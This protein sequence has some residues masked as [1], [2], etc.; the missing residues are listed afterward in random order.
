MKQRVISLFFLAAM[1]LVMISCAAD[2]P[3]G[4]PPEGESAPAEAAAR[5]AP[6]PEPASKSSAAQMP[7]ELRAAFIETMQREASQ[8]YAARQEGSGAFVMDNPAHRFSTALDGEEIVLSPR[9]EAWSLSVDTTAFGCEGAELAAS[10][11]EPAAEGNRVRY[12][13]DGFEEWY[14]NGPAGLEQGFSV[15]HSPA[16]DGPKVIRWRAG[17]ELAPMLEDEDGDER[18]EGVRFVDGE[19]QVRAR[20]ADLYVTDSA[21]KALAAWMTVEQG[22]IGIHWDDAGA[23]YPVVVDPVFVTEVAEL[24]AEDG[25]GSIRLGTSVAISGSTALVGAPY[26]QDRGQAAGAAYVFVYTGGNWTQQA[27]LTAPDGAVQD[28]FGESVAISGDT[29]LVGA[30][31]DDD[32][33]SSS[34]A[35][36]VF[37]RFGVSWTLQAKL[38]AADGAFADF[39]GSSVAILGDTALVG[40]PDDDDK[41]SNSGSVYVFVR[42]AVSWTQQAKLVAADGA[43][44][45]DFG[46]SVSLSAD[47]ALVGAP[48]D[49]DKGSNSGSAYVF[50]RAGASWTQ[51]AKLV[52][53]DGAVEDYFGTSVSLSTDT[54]L[55]GA[56]YDDDKG[57]NSGS[58]HVFV[59][60]GVTWFPQMKLTATDGATLDYFGNSVAVSG[61]TALVGS[62]Y[63]VGYGSAYVFARSGASWA[64]QQELTPADYPLGLSFGS[65][66]ALSPGKAL[67]GSPIDDSGASLPGSAYI[68]AQNG[69]TWAQEGKVTAADDTAGDRLGHSVAFFGDTAIMGAYRDDD[70]GSMS[71]SAHVF[72][73]TGASWARQVK[74]TAV[75]GAADDYFGSSVAVY[76]DTAL[77]GAYGDDDKGSSSGSTYVFVR[78]GS[79]W[80]Q[81]AKLTA[82]DGATDDYFGSSVAVYG[83]TALVGARGDDDKGSNS[84]SAYVFVRNGVSWTQQAKITAAD[85]AASDV[86]AYSVA[87]AGDTA[88]IGAYLD[89]D[90][91]SNS[92]STYVFVRT[93]GSWVQQAKLTAADGTENDTFGYS[94]AVAGDTALIGA[95]DDNTSGW[96]IGSAYVFKRTGQLWAQQA[97]LAAADGLAFDSFGSSVAVSGDMAIVGAANDDHNGIDTGSA[98]VFVRNGVNWTQQAKLTAPDGAPADQFGTSV[99]VSDSPMTALVG[100]PFHDDQG[101]DSGSVYVFSLS[102]GNGLPCASATQCQTGFCVDGVCCNTPCNEVCEACTTALKGSGTDGYCG[103][104]AEG[105]DPHNTC[106][107]SRVGNPNSCGTDGFCSVSG[108]CR[109]YAYGTTCGANQC[110]AGSVQHP[111]C[112]GVGT[113]AVAP[114]LDDCASYQCQAGACKTTCSGVQDCA[115]DAFCD[116]STLPGKCVPDKVL[117]AACSSASQCQSGYCADGVCC[118]ALC[119]GTCQACSAALKATGASGFCGS[120]KEGTDPHDS[121]AD[122]RA[123]NPDSCGADGVC[124]AGGTCRVYAYGTK[125]SPDECVAGS[126]QHQVCNGVG[127]C[128]VAP[129]LDDCA[130]YECEPGAGADD[131]ACKQTC[132]SD[133]DCFAD[134]FC[135]TT[136]LPAQCL[137]DK[138]LAA[139]CQSASECQ[140][141]FCADGLCCDSACAGDCRFCGQDQNGE[142]GVCH[143]TEDGKDPRDRCEEDLED[144]KQDG[145]CNGAG[146]C[147]L[148]K[149]SDPCGVPVCLGD[150]RYGEQICNGFG[151]CTPDPGTLKSCAPYAC[152]ETQL[153]G[154]CNTECTSDVDCANGFMCANQKCVPL[155]PLCVDDDTSQGT[156]DTL[157]ECAPYK[158]AEDT[159]ECRQ[160]CSS[161]DDCVPGNICDTAKTCVPLPPTADTADGCDCHVTGVT[162]GRPALP[163]ALLITSLL[164]LRRVRKKK[165]RRAPASPASP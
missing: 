25:P 40:A 149:Y 42:S 164:A 77:V 22:E 30:I 124:S 23:V 2:P 94:V 115:A 137:L 109:V 70:R 93:G 108:V 142:A 162:S 130:P 146:L 147:R 151:A 68:F 35:A 55:V 136:S 65:S 52:A 145:A 110:V 79:N 32:K 10:G 139:E 118:D 112:N 126:V 87:L 9:A 97:K 60:S 19:G 3:L 69:A 58:A 18:G 134:A 71:G 128:T 122:S 21:G 13:H 75:D 36:Y 15:D 165:P 135:D 64:Q 119:G 132:A 90:K 4:P 158:C 102:R 34:G 114:V 82:S 12:A 31:G 141:G 53:A 6:A 14:L 116:T 154:Q 117:G 89:D 61:D 41:G 51:Q 121:C 153:G 56:P 33:A 95:P 45:D 143:N 83:D 26:D 107:N 120:V 16:C 46:T 160:V 111:I 17:G 100:A 155:A 144:C 44:D 48:Y 148:H 49:D 96:I 29:A 133:A 1:W 131:G 152:V 113:C 86:F 99:Q 92:G 63:T 138:A 88:V 104:A 163:A 8:A 78:S 129:V 161:V 157:T 123:A 39:L 81:Q 84:G 67:V 105:T 103:A 47:T 43:V 159:G 74:L 85:G 24:L 127:T 125:C 91:G 72:V 150:L 156:D 38:T 80:T 59:R 37:V 20:Y 140:S 11:A 66:V 28:Y 7:K 76:G 98:Y 54:A 106:A 57:S 50:V 62:W 27:K 73:R 101:T 5:P